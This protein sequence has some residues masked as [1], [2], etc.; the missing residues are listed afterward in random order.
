MSIRRF[1]EG[2]ALIPVSADPSGPVE[3]QLQFSDGTHRTAGLWQYLSGSWQ[4]IGGGSGGIAKWVSATA[5]VVDDV[6]WLDADDKIYVCLTPNSDVTFTPANW[7]ALS[8]ESL[9]YTAENVANKS[10]NTSLGT[11]DTLYPTQNAVKSY[12]DGQIA[13][14]QSNYITNPSAEVNT[15][16]WNLYADAAA[17]APVDGTG[18]TATYLTLTR[19]TTSGEILSGSA[20]F[21]LAKSANNAQGMG[22]ST[23][24]TVPRAAASKPH[25]IIFNYQVTSNFSYTN[26]DIVVYLYD[27]SSG[28]M[29]QPVPYTLD[30]SG[31]AVCEFQM[32]GNTSTS[33]RLIFHVASTNAT[34]YDFIFDAVI[35]WES[36]TTSMINVLDKVYDRTAV[37][38]ITGSGWTT[39][40]AD[41]V[42]YKTKNGSWRLTFNVL[43]T[44]T[45]AS[46]LSLTFNGVTFKSGQ[47][48]V[49]SASY[50]PGSTQAYAQ[51]NAGLSTLTINLPSAYTSIMLSG[52]V[53]LASMPTWAVDFY[54]VS[55]S[56]GAETRVVAAKY[57]GTIAG[58]YNL[59][60]PIQ[61]G[62]KQIDTHGAVTTG[63]GWKFT[64]PVSGIYKVYGTIF[65]PS[66]SLG[67]YLYKNGSLVPG[68]MGQ[69][70]A[71]GH[72]DNFI[73]TVEVNAG[74][75][76]DV[77]PD[78]GTF[79]SDSYG[80]VAF[81][82]ISGP[83]TIAASEKVGARYSTST[84][85]SAGILNYDT[86]QY[87]T[88]NAVTTGAG[89]KF[90]VPVAGRYFIHGKYAL[91]AT[92]VS[93][94]DTYLQINGVTYSRVYYPVATAQGFL[95]GWGIDIVN[96]KVGDYIQIYFTTGTTINNS[97]H[98]YI[99]I[100][101]VS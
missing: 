101:K 16:G 56:D 18:G 85:Q 52:D 41:F 20:S 29:I 80:Y 19:T 65:G 13:T 39:Y 61:W 38:D 43:G 77:R 48:Q 42:P 87:D 22:V 54:P 25:K 3:G 84:A 68:A 10:T 14:S 92:A 96:L 82:R 28:T 7:Q 37:G 55:L 4:S 32:N 57:S 86:K 83:A 63:S 100:E 60:T 58:T 2:L 94:S 66:S 71:S 89:W 44:F 70:A 27:V 34:A 21:K 95:P 75:Y 64:A 88:H 11:S 79:S 47:S 31:K 93:A 98:N 99:E 81:E 6:V 17:A 1:K 33:Y 45:S 59:T 67:I 9:G 35:V 8:V 30:G 26:N 23:D 97:D 73:G 78:S 50:F 62:T 5:Y 72:W 36:Q 24:F 49:V 76:L 69:I 53:A 91:N 15:T 74:D 12:V 40:L 46:S 90:T 51:C